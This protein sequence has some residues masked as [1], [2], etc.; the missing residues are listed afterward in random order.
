MDYQTLSRYSGKF[1]QEPSH[2]GIE[3]DQEVPPHVVVGT[4]GGVS[5]IHHHP[6]KGFYGRGNT[7]S[8]VYAGQGYRYK[9]GVYGGL[10]EVGHSAGDQLS[11]F[12]SPPDT[13]FWKKDTP[14]LRGAPSE[15]NVEYFTELDID[16]DEEIEDSFELLDNPE[17]HPHATNDSPPIM[18]TRNVLAIPAVSPWLLL[19]LF[20]LISVAF[21]FWSETG[22]LFVRQNFHKGRSPGWMSLGLY[23]VIV[24]A[25]FVGVVWYSG[26]PITTLEQSL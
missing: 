18:K 11:Y 4:P 8:D 10:Y 5:S 16:N 24:T 7:S 1:Q 12:P 25:M 17:P 3:Y 2:Q 6:T 9:S 13:E 22:L 23:A 21:S 19:V 20:L 15:S 14:E 26:V